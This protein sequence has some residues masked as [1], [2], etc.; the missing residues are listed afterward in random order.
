MSSQ[1][2]PRRD[3]QLQ[4]NRK[5]SRAN[6]LVNRYTNVLLAR[7]ALFFYLAHQEPV[8][9][10]NIPSSKIMIRYLTTFTTLNI[11]FRPFLFISTFLIST[12]RQDTTLFLQCIQ[13]VFRRLA[14][15]QGSLLYIYN[16]YCY[17]DYIILAQNLDINTYIFAYV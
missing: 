1:K 17:F 6:I 11:A 5:C 14:S 7:P 16:S 4:I 8:K 9:V 10:L 2:V 3:A 15:P 12:S 13:H